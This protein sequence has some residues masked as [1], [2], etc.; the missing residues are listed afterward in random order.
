M[1]HEASVTLALYFSRCSRWR[2]WRRTWRCRT[3]LMVH[4]ASVTLA[5]YSSLL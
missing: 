1:V 4:E 5:L 2:G 3:G